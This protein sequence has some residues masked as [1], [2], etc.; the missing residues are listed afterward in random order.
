MTLSLIACG[1]TKEKSDGGVVVVPP[2]QAGKLK[3]MT[4]TSLAEYLK[5]ALAQPK[6]ATDDGGLVF[7]TASPNADGSASESVSS[8]NLQEA[9]VDEADLIKT[10]GRYIYSVAKGSFINT[11]ISNGNGTSLPMPEQQSDIIRIMD[12]ST[13]PLSEVKVIKDDTSAWNITGLYL[14]KDQLIATTSK[15]NNYSNQWFDSAAFSGQSTELIFMDVKTPAQASVTKTLKFDGSLIDSRRNGDILYLALRYYPDYKVIDKVLKTQVDESDLADLLPSYTTASNVQK[16]A[17]VKATDCY[18]RDASDEQKSTAGADI[19]TLVAIDLASS[20]TT[21]NSQ[22]YVGAAEALYASQNALY[23]ATTRYNYQV[24]DVSNNIAEYGTQISTDIH[25]FNYSG[26]DFDYRGSAEVRGH[27]GYQQ[28]R[29]SFRFS[30]SG[31]YLRVITFAENQWVNI[32]LPVDAGG[33]EVQEKQANKSPVSLTILEESPT[34]SELQ[35]V[36]Q[37]PNKD[38]PKP[39]G[40]KGEKLYASRYIGDKA[41]LVTFRVTDPLYVLDMSNPADPFIAGELKV[42]GYSDYLHPITEN[43]LLGIGKDAIPDTSVSAG[44]GRGAWYQGVKLSLIDVSDPSNPIERDKIVIGKRGTQSAVLLDHHAFTGI[45]KGSNYRFAIPI[46]LHDEYRQQAVDTPHPWDFY[47]WRSTGLHRYEIDINNQKIIDKQ[48]M[49]ASYFLRGVQPVLEG[50][51]I[52][53]LNDGGGA[54]K[55]TYNDRSVFIG[56]QVYYSHY[57]KYWSQDWDAET[58]M[59]G[60]K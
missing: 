51:G 37:L 42:E 31:D 15:Y 53:P 18:V 19:I 6:N 27:L 1:G 21:I 47:Q 48:A 9:G 16:Q 36:S 10:D 4:D 12:T 33:V 60:P 34:K 2:K 59:L 41:Y 32:G 40:L 14:D 39:I 30:E 46:K 49:L 23:L 55:N 7:S 52:V 25:K 20:E 44:D 50:D 38:R 58:P 26:L 57:G 45:K 43:L 29:K 28:D 17:L 5:K 56:D 24:S 3:R 54:S 13:N 35:V 22:C 8:T 11:K